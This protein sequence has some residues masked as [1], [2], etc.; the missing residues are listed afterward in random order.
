MPGGLRGGVDEVEAGGEQAMPPGIVR[1]GPGDDRVRRGDRKDHA[2]RPHEV[3]PEMRLLTAEECRKESLVPLGELH[4]LRVH[5]EVD[6]C[7]LRREDLAG[8]VPDPRNDFEPPVLHRVRQRI[9]DAIHG[10]DELIRTG[11][12][13]FQRQLDV[14]LARD[15][16]MPSEAR[17]LVMAKDHGDGRRA[18][19]IPR[20]V[21]N[22]ALLGERRRKHAVRQ[23]TVPPR[24]GVNASRGQQGYHK[25]GGTVFFHRETHGNSGNCSLGPLVA[26]TAGPVYGCPKRL[27]RIVAFSGPMPH[28]PST[29]ATINPPHEWCRGGSLLQPASLES[30][31]RYTGLIPRRIPSLPKLSSAPCGRTFPDHDAR[32]L[33]SIPDLHHLVAP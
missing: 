9:D 3:T 11:L 25:H 20:H 4:H 8:L 2:I 6:Q 27:T 24:N 31:L 26:S 30:S 22:R 16:H 13:A 32:G 10:Q 29:S 17:V 1:V 28:G 21:L 7:A 12:H 5:T 19:T 18:G 23:D 14:P 15:T 33:P